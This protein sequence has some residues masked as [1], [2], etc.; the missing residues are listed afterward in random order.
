MKNRA[1]FGMVQNRVTLFYAP[2]VTIFSATPVLI[3]CYDCSWTLQQLEK[4]YL[5]VYE[6]E[7]GPIFS[8]KRSLL[9]TKIKYFKIFYLLL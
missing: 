4:C 3:D 6:I 1:I 7:P 8:Q 5:W 9:K 2:Q